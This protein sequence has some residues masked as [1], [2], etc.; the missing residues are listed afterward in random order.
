MSFKLIQFFW[1]PQK[2]LF[3]SYYFLVFSSPTQNPEWN[4]CMFKCGLACNAQTQSKQE[5]R[6]KGSKECFEDR[7]EY[8]WHCSK[9]MYQQILL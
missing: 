1:P 4:C 9:K 5:Q 2:E 6:K 3:F 7:S 8:H